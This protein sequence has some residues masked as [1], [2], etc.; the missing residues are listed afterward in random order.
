MP[1]TVTEVVNS[2][3]VLVG[4]FASQ[5]QFAFEARRHFLGQRRVGDL[6]TDHLESNGNAEL[7]V[8][9][10]VDGSHAADAENVQDLVATPERLA[11][12]EWTGLVGT[13][14]CSPRSSRAGDRSFLVVASAQHRLGV[15]ATARQQGRVIVDA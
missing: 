11:D 6:G 4:D 12:G 9:G 7:L 14:R 1:S 15:V 5:Q 2:H 13:L 3:H 10:L 8:P